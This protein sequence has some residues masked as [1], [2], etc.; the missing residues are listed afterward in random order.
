[1]SYSKNLPD[2]C[3]KCIKITRSVFHPDCEFC[4]KIKFD[5]RIFCELNQAAQ[6]IKNF[7]CKTFRPLLRVLSKNENN[8]KSDL[9]RVPI[10]EKDIAQYMESDKLKYK[11]ALGLQKLRRNPD[12]V[13]VDLKYHIAWNT[14]Y[15]ARLFADFPGN[16]NCVKDALYECENEIGGYVFSVFLSEDHIHL[17]IESDGEKSVEEIVNI[18]KAQSEKVIKQQS[19]NLQQDKIWDDTYFVESIQ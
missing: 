7:N 18:L 8:V 13:M 1:M 12:T 2:L 6:N 3:S 16:I 17:C 9:S 5:E 10:K 19:L 15:R 14:A 11:K 4:E